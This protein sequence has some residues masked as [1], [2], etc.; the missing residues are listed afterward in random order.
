MKK[1]RFEPKNHDFERNFTAFSPGK[2]SQVV[3][4][5]LRRFV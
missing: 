1:R 4:L 2:A 3:A 5:M